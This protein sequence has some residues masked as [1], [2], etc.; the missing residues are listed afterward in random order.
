[1]EPPVEPVPPSEPPLAE[2]P[3]VV[4]PVVPA[5]PVSTTISAVSLAGSLSKGRDCP[6]KET[7]PVVR[8]TALSIRST[9]G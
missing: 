1:M 4:P 6:P 8:P 9:K 3:D 7:L 5:L 2:P